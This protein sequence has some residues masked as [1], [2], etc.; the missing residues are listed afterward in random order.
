MRT[1]LNIDDEVLRA[2][3]EIARQRNLPTGTVIS[4]LLREALTGQRP[5]GREDAGKPGSV[6]GFRPF[7]PREAPV[8]ND[9]IDRL[10]DEEGA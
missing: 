1:T 5:G 3:R 6:A 9:L 10:R 2:A 7:T 8:D 4:S